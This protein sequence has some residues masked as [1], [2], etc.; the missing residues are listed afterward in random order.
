[1]PHENNRFI[2]SPGVGE[3]EIKLSRFGSGT[4]AELLNEWK[5]GWNKSHM[6]HKWKKMGLEDTGFFIGHIELNF[7]QL[8]NKTFR[9]KRIA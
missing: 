5:L 2:T 7:L 4:W 9:S 8:L 3:R 1:M 6:D